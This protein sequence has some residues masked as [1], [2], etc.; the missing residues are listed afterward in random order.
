MDTQTHALPELRG[1]LRLM[2][3]AAARSGEPLWLI[4]DPLQNRYIQIDAATRSVLQLWPQHRTPEA[5]IAAAQDADIALDEDGLKRLIDFLQQNGLTSEPPQGGW[6]HYFTRATGRGRSPAAWLLHNYMFFR[7]PLWRPHAFLSRTL[8]WVVPLGSRTARA[9]FAIIGLAGLYLVSRQWDAYVSTFQDFFTWEGMLFM[10]AALMVVKAAH[11]L[12]HAYTA[13]YYGCHVPTMGV[14]FMLLAPLL[15]TDVTDAWR[16]RDRRQRLQIDSAGMQ[17]ELAIAAVALFLWSFLPDGP[18]RSIAFILSAV[19]IAM[20]LF[21]NLNP[22]MK[23]D[24]YYLLSEFLGVENLQSRAFALARWKLRE[25]LFGLG[26][27]CP[28]DIPPWLRR[29]LILYAYATWAYRLVLFIGIALL[30]YHYFFKVL[31]VLLFAVEIAFFVLRPLWSELK[32]WFKMK[33]QIIRS[34]RSLLTAGLVLAAV[35]ALFVPWSS[36]VEIPAI[37]QMAEMRNVHAEK[38]AQVTAVHVRHGQQ[39]TAGQPLI[40]LVSRDLD[41]ALSIAR[42]RLRLVQLRY[43]RRAANRDDRAASLVLEQEITALIEK[44]KG[45]KREQAELTIRAPITGR[46]LELNPRLHPGRWLRAKE[47]IAT[48]GNAAR[49]I[50]RGYVAE[51][52]MWRIQTGARGRFLPENLLRPALDVAVEEIGVGAAEAIEIPDLASTHTGRIAVQQDPKDRRLVPLTAQYPVRL[53]AGQDQPP[54]VAPS[55]A[56]L[57]ARGTV[58]VEGRPESLASR[59]WRQILKVLVRESGA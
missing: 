57:A 35:I 7:I 9:I 11:E 38:A 26:A 40:S 55:S 44:I 58:Q 20:S 21:I 25:V 12:G 30:V 43:A 41:H 42:T 8:P 5:L 46:V 28:E 3:G 45:L 15:Y 24:G 36:Q 52:N 10:M 50:A 29:V 2:R 14:A 59:I 1:E 54:A 16:L 18:L 53:R 13:R 39:V 4:F 6:R 48:I 33:K 31:G 17:V 56:A 22:F 19:S 23:F 47:R 37:L 32:V 49:Q 51:E 27:P 34:R